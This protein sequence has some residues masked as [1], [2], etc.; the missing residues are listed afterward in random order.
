MKFKHLAVTAIAVL[1]SFVP[2]H[3]ADAKDIVVFLRCVLWFV[4]HRIMVAYYL[5]LVK[6]L[7]AV[8]DEDLLPIMGELQVVVRFP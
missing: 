4:C 5:G 7:C 3:N 1:V 6:T 8:Y 2:V